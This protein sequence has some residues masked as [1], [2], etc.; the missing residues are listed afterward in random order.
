MRGNR[1]KMKK[2]L[3]LDD[4]PLTLEVLGRTLNLA[5]YECYGHQNPIHAL[6]WL[7]EGNDVDAVITDLKMPDM[8]GLDFIRQ[9]KESHP[10]I[11]ILAVTAYVDEELMWRN[12][13][14]DL[15]LMRKPLDL[16]VLLQWLSNLDASRTDSS[17]EKDAGIARKNVLKADRT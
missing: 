6:N 17:R 9:L 11:S 5:G 10:H 2:L 13:D 7:H 4:D 14:L 1:R 3:L 15:S 8:N 12:S 16:H